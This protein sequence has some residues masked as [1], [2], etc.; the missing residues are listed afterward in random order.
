MD[1][2]YG[3][4]VLAVPFGL[5]I[6]LGVEIVNRRPKST[7]EKVGEM[8][9]ERLMMVARQR[10]WVGDGIEISTTIDL[11]MDCAPNMQIVVRDGPDDDTNPGSK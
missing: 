5:G 1:M 4:L 6:V 3:A 11:P 10:R 7:N 9:R 8:I 2:L